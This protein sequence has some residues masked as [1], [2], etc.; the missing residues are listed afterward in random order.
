[1][2]DNL[3]NQVTHLIPLRTRQPRHTYALRS[4]S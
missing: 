3:T 1:L 2:A 4:T